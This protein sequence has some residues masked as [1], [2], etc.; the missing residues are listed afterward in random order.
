M[1]RFD[2]AEVIRTP[3]MR[4]TL[5]INEPPYE[6]DDVEYVS[7]VRGRIV[8]TN[9]GTMLLV[10]GPID[11]VIA[12]HC[13]R[14]LADVRVPIHADLEEDFDLKVVDDPAHHNKAVEV[15]EEDE[16]GHVFEGKVLRLDVLIR[17][18]ALLAAPLQPLCRDTCPGIAPAPDEA[19]PQLPDSPFQ[20]LSRLLDENSED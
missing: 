12:E 20:V 17:Q 13:S 19:A 6:D 1:L 3:G 10:R 5:E 16:I 15:V 11:T 9:T 18:A 7:P 4:Q 14:C 2:L 8:V